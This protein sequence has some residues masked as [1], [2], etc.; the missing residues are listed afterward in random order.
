MKADLIQQVNAPIWGQIA[1]HW[2]ADRWARYGKSAATPSIYAFGQVEQH[3]QG[4]A[5]IFVT[6]EMQ[7]LTYR[8]MESFDPTEPVTAEEWFIPHGIALLD[9]Q[10]LAEDANGKM[11]GWRAVSWQL[12][13]QLPYHHLGDD[14]ALP[15]DESEVRVDGYEDHVIVFLWAHVDDVD[16]WTEFE[17]ETG[18]RERAKATGQPWGVV[19]CTTIPLRLMADSRHTSNEGDPRA[20]WIEFIRV[21]QRLMQERIVL[22]SRYTPQR[23]LRRRAQRAGMTEINDVLVVELRRPRERGLDWEERGS[24]DEVH[25]SHRFMVSGHWRNQWYPTEKTHRQKWISGYVK[26]PD[27]KPLILKEKVWVWDR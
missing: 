18:M 22:K 3:L 6:A 25:Y 19:H 17:S 20:S 4:A 21:L 27:D 23:P 10:V 15:T 13:R 1:E 12:A 5:P 14:E 11:T 9:T 24:G 16:D 26:G 2:A 7:E 8:A